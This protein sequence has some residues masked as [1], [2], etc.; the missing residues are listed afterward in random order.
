[1]HTIVP[2]V[3]VAACAARIPPSRVCLGILFAHWPTVVAG[4]MRGLGHAHAAHGGTLESQSQFV[5]TT[6]FACDLNLRLKTHKM[7]ARRYATTR[8]AAAHSERRGVVMFLG[9]VGSPPR[10]GHFRAAAG[11]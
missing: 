4:A 10:A 2:I 1:M 11:R 3:P 9:F 8:A 7:A 5:F 6:D